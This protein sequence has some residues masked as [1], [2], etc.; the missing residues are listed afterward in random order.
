MTTNND[1][2]KDSKRDSKNTKK[3]HKKDGKDDIGPLKV[4]NMNFEDIMKLA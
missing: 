2:K 4:D 1:S 3:D